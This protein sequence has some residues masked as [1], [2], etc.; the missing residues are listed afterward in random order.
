MRRTRLV[1][2]LSMS[3]SSSVTVPSAHALRAVAMA[4]PRYCSYE[5]AVPRQS[6]VW[7]TKHA[8]LVVA[9]VRVGQHQDGQQL[10]RGHVLTIGGGMNGEALV[11]LLESPRLLHHERTVLDAAQPAA[12]AAS[13]RRRKASWC[14][15]R[16]SATTSCGVMC[17]TPTAAAPR[18][19]CPRQAAPT[20]AAA[21][22]RRRRCRRP[23]RARGAAAG[24]AVGQRQQRAGVVG[25]GCSVGSPR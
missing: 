2:R 5:N 7:S 19:A 24:Q 11:Q 21:C 20:T 25:S 13:D 9:Q 1:I 8:Q 14:S 3:S 15:S 4:W 12:G 10:D 18:G 23:G 22:G 6:S 16:F 17:V